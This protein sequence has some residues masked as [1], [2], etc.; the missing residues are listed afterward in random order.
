MNVFKQKAANLNNFQIFLFFIKHL[1]YYNNSFPSGF[2]NTLF[3]SLKKNCR[4]FLKQGT[5]FVIPIITMS[6]MFM[7]RVNRE[8]SKSR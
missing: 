6:C 1:I 3:L 5:R 7:P 8:C 2:I 4:Q